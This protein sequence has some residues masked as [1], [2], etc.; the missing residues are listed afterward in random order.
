MESSTVFVKLKIPDNTAISA[1]QTL[2][3]MGF[4][5]LQN[6]ERMEYYKFLISG[7]KKDFGK[8]IGSVDIICNANKHSMSYSLPPSIDAVSFLIKDDGSNE[9]L[10]HTLKERL[11]IT[12]IRNIDKGMVWTLHF[13]NE[14]SIHKKG[15]EIVKALLMNPHYQTM[16]L[17]R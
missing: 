12:E 2:Q 6:V 15:R 14:K 8:K 16:E 3:R 5:S 1:L 17:M 13:E 4:S 9:G 10:L 7:N 11:H